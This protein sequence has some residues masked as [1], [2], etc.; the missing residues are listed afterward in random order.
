MNKDELKE[1]F[2]HFDRDNNGKI[3]FEEFCELLD[4]MNSDMEDIA[5]RLGFDVIDSDGNGSIEFDE[6]CSWWIEQSGAV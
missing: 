5:R 4:A 6:F 2:D 1:T 3:D